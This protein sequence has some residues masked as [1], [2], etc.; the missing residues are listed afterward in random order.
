MTSVRA[1]SL[2]PLALA[3]AELAHPTTT[4]ESVSE[5]IRAAGMWWLPLHLVLLIGYALL[6]AMLWRLTKSPLAHGALAGFAACNCLYLAVDGIAVGV[7]A[8]ANPAVADALWSAAWVNILAD[9]TGATWAASL[10]LL[11]LS[12]GGRH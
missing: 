4:D 1:W 6:V 9:A 2:L 10:L 12:C 11:G 8:Q 3:V 5:S 7:L